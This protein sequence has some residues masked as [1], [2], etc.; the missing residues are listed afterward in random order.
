MVEDI[1]DRDGEAAEWHFDRMYTRHYVCLSLPLTSLFDERATFVDKDWFPLRRQR[2]TTY[3]NLAPGQDLSGIVPGDRRRIVAG[4]AK[5]TR[6]QIG[7][8]GRTDETFFK[9]D[10]FIAEETATATTSKP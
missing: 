7:P 9:D 8:F 3:V 10:R 4:P 2:P 1:R 5:F 6:K